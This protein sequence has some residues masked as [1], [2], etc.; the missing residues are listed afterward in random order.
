MNLVKPKKVE[1]PALCVVAPGGDPEAISPIPVV[2]KLDFRFALLSDET[3]IDQY[4]KVNNALKGLEKWAEAA[5]GILKE[6]LPAPEILTPTVRSGSAYTAEYT[7][8]ERIA[9]SQERV[10]EFV[11]AEIYLSLC[12]TTEVFTLK[13]KP[14]K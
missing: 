10:K 1:F 2:E 13:I 6:R 4:G 14:I 11:G 3:L 8:T 12:T 7:K 9:L 5:K